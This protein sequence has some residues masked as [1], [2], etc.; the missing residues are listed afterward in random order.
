MILLQLFLVFFK[1][2]LLT[3]GGGYAM[4]PMIQSETEYYHWLTLEELIDFIAVS[5]STPGPFAVNISTFVGMETAGFPGAVC[6]TL[7]VAIPSFLVI[8]FVARHYENFQKNRIVKGCMTG[9]KP[10]VIGMLAASLFS[11]AQT[12]MI[13][14]TGFT[15][16]SPIFYISLLILFIMG[17]LSFRKMHP[18][19]IIFLSALM[20]IGMG[21]MTEI[22]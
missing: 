14:E 21:Y 11:L 8:L 12:V 4:L 15:W 1:I 18:I 19:I 13:P 16:N 20:G 5:E 22:L 3:F 6:A 2:G 17:I 9:L 10:A 7:G